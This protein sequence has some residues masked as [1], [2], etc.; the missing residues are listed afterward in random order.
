MGDSCQNILSNFFCTFSSKHASLASDVIYALRIEAQH[1]MLS[2]KDPDHEARRRASELIEKIVPSLP[3]EMQ[4]DLA[5]GQVDLSPLA[6]VIFSRIVLAA[7]LQACGADCTE[8][9]R[10]IVDCKC[11]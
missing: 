3:A 4:E 10:R 8:G 9:C 2:E 5:R 1:A 6:A 7:V 11:R